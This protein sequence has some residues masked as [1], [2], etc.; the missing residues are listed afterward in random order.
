MLI[1]EP[2]LLDRRRAA[3]EA[4][5]CAAALQ[6]GVP[7]IS[8]TIAPEHPHMLRDDYPHSIRRSGSK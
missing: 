1:S 4:G 6:F 2:T 7:I 3:H 5:H 8:C